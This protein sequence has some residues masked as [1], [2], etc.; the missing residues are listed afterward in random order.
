MKIINQDRNG[1]IKLGT[2]FIREHSI[3]GIPLGINIYSRR[4]LRLTLLGT[5]D[6]LE[7]A[8]QIVREIV[9]LDKAGFDRYAMPELYTMDVD[10]LE[11]LSELE[12]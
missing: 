5:Y 4:F 2:L 12:G 7:D 3:C 8:I 1:T 10:F 11:L 9:K 6:I